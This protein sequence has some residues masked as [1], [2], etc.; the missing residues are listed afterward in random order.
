M[1]TTVKNNVREFSRKE[2]IF[3]KKGEEIHQHY[4]FGKLF[5]QKKFY[6]DGRLKT[7]M[8]YHP[9]GVIRSIFDYADD[10]KRTLVQERRYNFR[11]EI[12]SSMLAGCWIINYNTNTSTK[13]KLPHYSTLIGTDDVAKFFSW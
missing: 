6:P 4:M 11:G 2:V 8:L 7:E 12:M 5:S 9:N 3:N 10:E 1:K 13:C